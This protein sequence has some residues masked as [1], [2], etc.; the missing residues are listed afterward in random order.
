MTILHYILIALE[1]VLVFNLIIGVHE[2]GHFLAARWRGL[3]VERLPN[4]MAKR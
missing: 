4:Q 2:V 1:V 3:K